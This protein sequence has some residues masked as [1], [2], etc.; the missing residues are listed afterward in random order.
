MDGW[1]LEV[2]AK[3]QGQGQ[4]QGEGQGRFCGR[5]KASSVILR[6]TLSVRRIKKKIFCGRTKVEPF[7]QVP[8]L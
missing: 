2:G 7:F 3:G 5:G 8:Y 1:G 6:I 4:G